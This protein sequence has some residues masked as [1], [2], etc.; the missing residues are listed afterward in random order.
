MDGNYIS[1]LLGCQSKGDKMKNM[2]YFDITNYKNLVAKS[3]D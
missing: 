2:I 1:K 3:V